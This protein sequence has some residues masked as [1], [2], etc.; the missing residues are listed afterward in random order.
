M[1][2]VCPV[3]PDVPIPVVVT[4]YADKTFDYVRL[5]LRDN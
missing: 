1:D 3:Q 2:R 4:A 5:V